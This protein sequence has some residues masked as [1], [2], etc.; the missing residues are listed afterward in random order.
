MS[1][2]SQRLSGK[3]AFITGTGGGMG[4]TAAL[5]FAAE[6]ASVHGADLNEE[7]ARETLELVHAA[8][9]T[10]TSSEPIDFADREA[11]S[12]WIDEGISHH[13]RMDV[14]YNNASAPRFRPFAEMTPE[15]WSFDIRN[16]LDVVFHVTQLSWPHL[17]AAQNASVIN[18]GSQQGINAVRSVPGGFAHAAAKHGVIGMTREL[19]SEGGPHGI[20]VNTISPGM[21]MTPATAMAKEI[22]GMIDAFLDHQI[23]KRTGASED[24]VNAAIYLA[25]DESTFVTGIN[26]V[27][28]G[29]YTIV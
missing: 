25:S 12:A 18:I 10:M 15:E 5:M 8:G 17:I 21:I 29:G 23:I 4:R 26:L 13:G 24:V 1:S 16:E 19:A 28:D 9:G 6:G 11:V 20:R 14:L 22:P 7:T 3:V 2:S 27:V